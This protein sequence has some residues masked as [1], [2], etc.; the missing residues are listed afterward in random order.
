MVDLL[1]Q[2]LCACA[3]RLTHLAGAGRGLLDR[4]VERLL[5]GLERFLEARLGLLGEGLILERIDAI[6]R[7]LGRCVGGTEQGTERGDQR[8]ARTEGAVESL[9][10]ETSGGGTTC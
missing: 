3:V 5:E 6:D 2:H 7:V 8:E 1:E 9:H 4:G 10:E